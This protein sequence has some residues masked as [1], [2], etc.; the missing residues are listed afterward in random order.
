MFKELSVRRPSSCQRRRALSVLSLCLLLLLA[1][2]NLGRAATMGVPSFREGTGNKCELKKDDSD[3]AASIDE[4]AHT[5]RPGETVG[6]EITGGERHLYKIY[7]SQGQFFQAVVE[8]LGVDV[9]A[10]ICTQDGRR[11]A[12]VDR[13]SGSW[14][15]EAISLIAKE[16]GE[17]R[18]Q[19]RPIESVGIGGRYIIK[20]KELRDSAP[21]DEVQ[22]EA[23]RIVTEG[24]K[25]FEKGKPDCLIESIK[26]YE[27]ALKLWQSLSNDLEVAVTLYGLGWSHTNLGAHGMVKFPLS[28][29]QLRWSY[30][31]RGEH[32]TAL[33]YFDQSLR[34]MRVLKFQHGQAIALTGLAYPN[35]YL[36]RSDEALNNFSDARRLFNS[37]GNSKGEAIATYGLGWAYALLSDD[38]KARDSFLRALE[39]RKEVKDRRG[40][41][42]T[43]AAI[44]R[45]YSRLNNNHEALEYGHLALDLYKA[46]EDK[47]G[48]ASM[49]NVLGWIHSA[50]GRQQDALSSFGEAIKL[51]G[52][53]DP[54]GVANS[55]YGIARVRSE[56]GDLIDAIEKMKVVVDM[57][58]EL[59]TKG[60]SSEVRTY[61][62]AN[63][64]EYYQFYVDI[65]MRAHQ[66]YPS[67]G[68]AERALWVNERALARELLAV[69]AK[70]DKGIQYENGSK[71]A[72]ASNATGIRELLDDD[73]LLLEY[74]LGAERSY[75]WLVSS[76]EV[77]SYVLPKGLEIENKAL[78][79]YQLLTERNR[80]L[81]SPQ[82]RE[83]RKQHIFHADAR[84]QKA[85]EDLGRI[86]LGP[87][88]EHLTVKRLA[89]ITQGSLQLVPFGALSKPAT[90]TSA[91]IS[92]RPLVVDHEVVSLPSA[93][94][95]KMLRHRAGRTS[96]AP[97]TIA[98]LADPVFTKGDPRINQRT[99]GVA[100]GV[101]SEDKN[102]S[103]LSLRVRT[104]RPR[105]KSVERNPGEEFRRLPGTRW[106]AQQIISL[107]PKE[108]GFMALDFSASRD[109]AMSEDL[110]QYRIV[111]FA[112]HAFVDDTD[113][114]LSKIVF[115]QYDSQG[116]PQNGNL[117]LADIHQMRLHADLV[118]LSAC[119]TALGVDTKGE[120]L[121]GLTGGFMRQR[122]PRVIVT[123]WP[124]SD[125]VAAEMMAR[126]YRKMLGKQKLSPAA[127]LREVQI[128]MLKDARWNSAYFWA[129]FIIQGEWH[130]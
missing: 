53:R 23:E 70:S 75:L 13:Q 82:S 21:T 52:D 81:P 103:A 16:D 61:Y 17:Y 91:T 41:A 122:V 120:G 89:V 30:E 62:F 83:E 32:L 92:P 56:Q 119:R 47:H 112:T 6:R 8:Q 74:A 57:V 27:Q 14:G 4:K 93:S 9:T 113:P 128:E 34:M 51:R 117:A 121:I 123:L 54:T 43:L 67:D 48:Q 42:N 94:I 72:E 35:L 116:N 104:D 25:Y 115:S 59:R 63:F 12:E 68:F 1:P 106:E 28:R 2:T 10:S 90:S 36:G 73:T 87:V 105:E 80:N 15:P 46:L 129:P 130:W 111:H 69:L 20:I 44:S 98:V 19:V 76:K 50:Q 99:G 58:E 49:Y 109:M 26:K 22:V 101:R 108:D 66:L 71:L 38:Q 95:M 11:V 85:A 18:L 86:L 114:A 77:L 24:G 45:I 107:V 60:G 100:D 5:L 55:L 7:L 33:K 79:L 31:S 96:M 124:I 125:S 97:K 64:N 65:L 126:L 3:C 78:H 102:G 127:A 40:E 29:N 39:L 110:G 118:V 88:A 84:A 37:L